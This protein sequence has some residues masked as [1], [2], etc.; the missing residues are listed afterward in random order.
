MNISTSFLFLFRLRPVPFPDLAFILFL[1][2]VLLFFFMDPAPLIE[3]ETK[4]PKY[5]PSSIVKKIKKIVVQ[6]S[7][8]FYL[9]L[10]MPWEFS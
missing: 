10:I 2:N 1:R 3:K 5:G 8:F 7:F 9:C 4:E 6:C